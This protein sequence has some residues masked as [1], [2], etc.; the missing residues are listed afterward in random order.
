MSFSSAGLTA[1]G[2]TPEIY[3][4]I[5][6]DFDTPLYVT[7]APRDISYSSQ[8]WS[9]NALL[10]SIGKLKHTLGMK[11]N[12]ISIDMAG[13]ALVNQLLTFENNN[14]KEVLIYRYLADTQEARLEFKGFIQTYSKKENIQ[15][16]TSV[17]SWKIA[18]HWANWGA[19]VGRV[20]N[21][22]EQQAL[23]PGDRFFE[24]AEVTDDKITDWAEADADF[25]GFIGGLITG[26]AGA[27]GDLVVNTIEVVED[28]GG[29]ID[30]ILGTSIFGGGGGGGGGA[31]MPKVNVDEH[32]LNTGDPESRIKRLPVMYGEGRIKGRVVFRGLDPA[33]KEFLY[34]VY[35]LSEGKIDGL[36]DNKLEFKNGEP[37]TSSRISPY[38]TLVAEYDGTQTAADSTLVSVFSSTGTGTGYL[39]ND[40]SSAIGDTVIAVDTGT[41]TILV[42]D[43]VVFG[44]DSSTYRVSVALSGGSFTIEDDGL[45]VALADNATVTVVSRWSASHI[46]Y[47]VAYSV[48]K[49]KKSAVWQG[50]P[51]PAHVLKGKHILDTRTGVTVYSANPALIAYDIAINTLYGKSVD[52]GDI[53][54]A[55]INA[56]ADL[57]ETTNTDHDGTGT[58]TKATAATTVDL[59]SFNGAINTNQP[60]KANMEKVLYNMRGHFPFVYGQYKLVI[61]QTNETSVYSFNED[62]ITGVFSVAETPAT[63]Q[64]NAVYYE[65][66]APDFDYKK[67]ACVVESSTYLAADNGIKQY[68]VI[69]NPYERNRYRGLN[70]AS[71]I[72]KKSRESLR[73]KLTAA[74]ADALQVEV[75]QL[76]DITRT[77]EGWTAKLF[78]VVGMT[79]SET[80]SSDFALEEY[81]SSV[82]DWGVS[83]EEA[84]PEDTTLPDNRTVLPPTGLLAVSGTSNQITT[85]DGA[86]EN[87]IKV[88]WTAPLDEYVE[89]YEVQYRAVGD[90][91]WIQLPT[92]TDISD[93]TLFIT[94]VDEDQDYEV[95]V[96]SYNAQGTVS[97]WVALGAAHTVTGE[98]AIGRLAQIRGADAYENDSIY[99]HSLFDSIDQFIQQNASVNS[100]LGLYVAGNASSSSYARK[101]V[102]TP[103]VQTTWDKNRRFRTKIDMASLNNLGGTAYIGIG[104]HSGAF[105]GFSI[106]WNGGTSSIDIYGY[107]YASSSSTETLIKSIVSTGAIVDFDCVFT[108]G[109]NAVLIADASEITITTTL[110]S[111]IGLYAS[112]IMYQY[113]PSG[114]ASADFRTGQ[115][116][117]LQEQ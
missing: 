14:N 95:R 51:Q 26:V 70:R 39:L 46:G 57:A 1:L 80:G 17:I 97:A 28:I 13:S 38:C 64:L 7:T 102:Y 12:T 87:R 41:G 99:W 84:L 98:V 81:E 67:Y 21:D 75:G 29:H 96:R 50:E 9:S 78:R 19:R 111:G 73:V 48:V 45:N 8:T 86:A 54:I 61:E 90:S 91:T 89:G 113:I 53:D 18:S 71:T 82:Y 83:V 5:K 24:Y 37:Y 22:R 23:Y 116:K 34:I 40:A 104:H 109:A 110:P 11:P 112:D 88:S 60:L 6:M 44:G 72:M 62:N 108:S 65:V 56:G 31:S 42:G 68:R 49:Y 35:A 27:V 115:W 55:S 30:N 94:K 66:I 63:G 93:V 107:T 43:I 77:S 3:Y 117:F 103:V 100:L 4:L 36:T 32:I 85:D 69:D 16:G 47:G 33:N 92:Q 2:D 106:K 76:V 52:T 25:G 59:F 15:K 114:S 58:T 79:T 20:I 10:T 74:N 105:V 101:F